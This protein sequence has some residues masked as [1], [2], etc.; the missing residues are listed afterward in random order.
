M[1]GID[2]G[3]HFQNILSGDKDFTNKTILNTNTLG[4][5]RAFLLIHICRCLYFITFYLKNR[6]FCPP[7]SARGTKKG[8]KNTSLECLGHK[9]GTKL[10]FS[11]LLILIVK[12]TYLIVLQ[13]VSRWFELKIVDLYYIANILIIITL[14]NRYFPMQKCLKMF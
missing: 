4:F 9:R 11:T 2:V 5:E 7:K 6:H 14:T 10:N 3:Q 1:F 12:L 8:Q 13:R